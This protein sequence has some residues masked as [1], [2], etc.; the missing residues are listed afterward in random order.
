MT[1]R[2]VFGKG[3]TETIV[4]DDGEMPSYVETMQHAATGSAPWQRLLS[5]DRTVYSSMYRSYA[6]KKT[7][8]AAR[9]MSMFS[10]SSTQPTT[11]SPNAPKTPS[12]TRRRDS[13]LWA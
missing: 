13:F 7:A 11:L 8:A 10:F 5:T 1:Q 4:Q 3:T 6:T 12:N 2:R 9:W